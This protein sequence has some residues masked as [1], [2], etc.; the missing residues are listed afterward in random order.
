MSHIPML[1]IVKIVSLLALPALAGRAAPAVVPLG[2][3]GAPGFESRRNEPEEAKD[4][5]VRNIHSPSLTVFLPP[6]NK[7]NGCAIV[8]APGGGLRELVFHAEGE[9]AAQYLNSLGVTV[10]VLKYRLPQQEGSP[11]ALP[12]VQQDA[13]RAVRTVRSRAAE[14]GIDPQRIGMLGFSAGG[15]VVLSTV[16]DTGNGDPQAA[17]P[18]ERA[19]SRPNSR[20][21]SIPPA[22]SPRHFR[23]TR[24]RRGFSARST[25]S[26]VAMRWRCSWWSGSGRR[27]CPSNSTCLR[28][29]STASTWATARSSPPCAT[30]P[31]AS[32]TGCSTAAT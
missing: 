10:F 7:A 12:H 31:T 4:Y 19:N 15:G 16:F 8:V 26:T 22:F 14:F 17:D 27:R 2:E 5:W 23:P 6:A 25:T 29:G 9:Q 20:C 1:R 30:G 13:Q 3:G 24:L 32:A 21:W 18:V 11:Y 28:R